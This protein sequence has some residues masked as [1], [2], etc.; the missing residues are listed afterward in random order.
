MIYTI[1]FTGLSGSGKTTIATS[2]Q[3]ALKGRN[4]NTVLLD[5]DAV[6]QM[7]SFDLSVNKHGGET[8]TIR[9]AN[10]CYLVNANGISSIACSISPTRSLRKYARYLTKNF[11]EVYMKC[12]IEICNQR[13]VKG[14]I[15]EELTDDKKEFMGINQS[16]E[17][18]DKPELVLETDRL[19][20]KECVDA[21]ISYLEKN[22]IIGGKND[23]QESEIQTS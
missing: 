10:M 20:V 13:E 2:L 4:E 12:P 19:P 14:Y 22:N 8:H 16:F 3:K 15:K 5:G 1:W 17:E 7:M 9:I 6:R 11:I 21:I 23:L 18:P